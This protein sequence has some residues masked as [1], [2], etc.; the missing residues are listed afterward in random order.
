MMVMSSSKP[1]VA[2]V[3]VTTIPHDTPTYFHSECSQCSHFAFCPLS[4]LSKQVVVVLVIFT[5]LVLVS[6]MFLFLFLRK[7]EMLV[8]RCSPGVLTYI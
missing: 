7:S 8:Q 6:S 5:C 4:L 3:S 1:L 2:G